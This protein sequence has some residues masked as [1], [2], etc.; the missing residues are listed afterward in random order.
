MLDTLA[1]LCGT[2]FPAPNAPVR[3]CCSS[4]ANIGD[5]LCTALLRLQV[6]FGQND[7]TTILEVGGARA[8]GSQGQ[9]ALQG[10]PAPC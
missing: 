10:A 2:P 8:Q 5:E 9:V 1:A 3:T 7:T 6:F 4:Q